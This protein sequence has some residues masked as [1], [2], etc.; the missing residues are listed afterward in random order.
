M[1]YL[2]SSFVLILATTLSSGCFP[3]GVSKAGTT[4]LLIQRGTNVYKLKNPKDTSIESFNVHPDGSF[5]LNG[6]RAVVN[7]HFVKAAQFEAEARSQERKMMLDLFDRGVQA[8]ADRYGVKM[9]PA[10]PAPSS[11][12]V[13]ATVVLTNAPAR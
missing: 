6:Y 5:E 13:P 9:A 2:V 12:T 7:E 3:G 4:E 8:G 10:N 1:K 11:V